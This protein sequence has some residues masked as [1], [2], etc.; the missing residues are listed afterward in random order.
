MSSLRSQMIRMASELPQGDPTRRKLLAS[1]R[2]MKTASTQDWFISI[3]TQNTRA[4]EQAARIMRTNMTL[5]TENFSFEEDPDRVDFAV[6][7]TEED[8]TATVDLLRKKLRQEV[9]AYDAN[10][11]DMFVR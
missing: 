3:H 11:R 1:L 10:Y 9:R 7:G 5:R 8:L 6:A 2:G 4:V